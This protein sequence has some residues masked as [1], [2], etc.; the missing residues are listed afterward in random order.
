MEKNPQAPHQCEDMMSKV[1]LSLDGE[2][3]REEE[4]KFLEELNQCSCCLG[5]YEIE[6]SFKE[7]LSQK[8]NKS[9]CFDTLAISIKQ[10]IK[11]HLT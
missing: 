4:K 6:K 7:F 8:V 11:Q 3:S 5:K 10:K 9:C 2:L 1:F